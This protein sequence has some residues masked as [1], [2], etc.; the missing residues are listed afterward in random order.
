MSLETGASL[1]EVVDKA[2]QIDADLQT[3]KEALAT[4]ITS[5]KVPTNATDSLQVM[6]DNIDSI[7][8]RSP[9]AEDE[10]GV[11]QW[12]DGTYKGFKSTTNSI[13]KLPKVSVENRLYQIKASLYY[14]N[15]DKN[16]FVYGAGYDRY[17]QD[18]VLKKCD[19]EN[20]LLW[21]Y[22]LGNF[23]SRVRFDAQNNILVTSQ[24]K[25]LKTA[26]IWKLTDSG[27]LVWLRDLQADSLSG[28]TSDEALN[29][30]VGT[31]QT[32]GI[33]HKIEKINGSTGELIK[34]IN[35]P[36]WIKDIS[37]NEK[38]QQ[39]AVY[40]GDNTVKFYDK[41]LNLLKSFSVSANPNR[42]IF[43]NEGSFTIFSETSVEFHDNIGRSIWSEVMGSNPS[44]VDV[45][46]VLVHYICSASFLRAFDK[47]GLKIT[48]STQRPEG[49]V[50]S[51]GANL[52]SFQ[53]SPDVTS[54]IRIFKD[55]YEVNENIVIK[56]TF[57]QI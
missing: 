3:K 49:N 17:D 52:V 57:N 12:A 18:S 27:T 1:K 50:T 30:Y 29:V 6:K 26:T 9:I 35:T 10:I 43:H 46:E 23:V 39:L 7:I 40:A 2:E 56:T 31:W 8:V 51:L 53:T 33:T 24:G 48:E 37:Y 44:P 42:I 14:S 36:F 38:Q 19:L 20:R 5:K 45:N 47:N 32:S 22:Q 25:T 4:A 41:N 21:S 11:V 16:R 28:C 15:M 13:N 34:S 54:R 55:N